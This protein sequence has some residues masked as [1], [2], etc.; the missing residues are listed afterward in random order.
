MRALI[1]DGSLAHDALAEQLVATLREQLSAQAYEVEHVPLRERRIGNCAGDFF[2]WVRSPGVCMT[3]DDNR[4]L[5]ASAVQCDLLILLSPVTFGGYS[6]TLKRMLDHLIQ[7]IMP[8]FT[9]IGGEVHHKPRYERYPNI[10][11]VG[12]TDGPDATGEAVFRHLVKRN[13]INMYARTTVSDIVYSGR[14]DADLA[15][16]CRGWLEAIKRGA[17][18]PVPA[19]PETGPSTVTAEPARRAVLLVG[20]PRTTKSSSAA[21]GG[22]LME[23]LA[24]R[25]A[26]TQSF[27]IYTTLRSPERMAALR[28]AV[29]AADLVVLAFPLYIDTLPAPV[30]ATLE[31]LAADR[32]GQG[33]GGRFVAIAN[34]GF[35]E[36]HHCANAMQVCAGFARQA[37]LAWAGGL[38]LGAGEGVVQG[39][40]LGELGGMAAP[41]RRALDIAATSLAACRIG[42]SC[43]GGNTSISA[44][45]SPTR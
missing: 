11:A 22:Y 45:S 41:V 39:K 23:R 5:A 10:L 2:C 13:A 26:A 8:F 36:A 32:A 31:Q 12:W 21:L 7:N 42:S 25:G 27:Q 33:A 43:G 17:S 9:Q 37:G 6:S 38:S 44:R 35:P 4:A 18:S 20:S 29:A 19:L 14:P 34:C 30:I 40:P 16:R 1:L 28:E 3:D 24:E 15:G